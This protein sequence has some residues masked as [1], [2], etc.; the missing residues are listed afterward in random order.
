M[1]A[2]DGAPMTG[3][4][5]PLSDKTHTELRAAVYRHTRAAWRMM[6]K[7]LTLAKC[8]ADLRTIV[9][10]TAMTAYAH[11]CCP[12]HPGTDHTAPFSPKSLAA[13]HWEESPTLRWRYA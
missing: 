6:D 5:V 9:D 3:A 1:K 2:R 8:R 10:G 11:G 4:L 12:Q 7:G 13:S